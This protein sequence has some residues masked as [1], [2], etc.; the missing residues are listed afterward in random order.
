VLSD[1][2]TWLG[3]LAALPEPA[4]AVE[5]IDL[6]TVV[7]QFTALRHEVNLQTKATRSAVDQLGL[8]AEALKDRPAADDG[9]KPILK[10]IVDVYDNLA[11]ALK[12]VERQRATIEPV[13]ADLTAGAEM[14]EPPEVTVPV[15]A[16]VS[17]RPRGF[18]SRLFGG[19]T[20]PAEFVGT[21][22]RQM[23]ID[24]REG[25]LK[26]AEARRSRVTDTVNQVRSSL[27]G[28]IAGYRMS[29][30]RVDRAIGLIGLEPIPAVGERFDPEL[31]E[32]VEVVAEP[33]RPA[34]EVVQ[35]VRRGYRWRGV[36][37]RF[38]Q[39]KVSR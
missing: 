25:V 7:G 10:A 11:L 35:E 33:G 6:H 39:V 17:D 1:F 14:P 2:R 24:W 4:E 16:G 3:E 20:V 15:V 21:V 12:Q 26:D 30:N 34:G 8:A 32:A 5:T 36:V 23:L 29:L 9:L 19:S 38:A 22:H 18:W 28:L 27:D 31:M 37:F 13:L